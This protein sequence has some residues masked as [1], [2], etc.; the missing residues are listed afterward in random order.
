MLHRPSHIDDTGAMTTR[1]TA[2]LTGQVLSWLGDAFQVVA[3]PV[4]IVVA[5]GSA[6][7][8]AAAITATTVARLVFTLFGGVWADR[9]QPRIVMA[10]SDA[11]RAACG[12]VLACCFWAGAWSTPVI[13]GCAFVTAAAGAFY[14]SLIHI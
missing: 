12:L 8:M 6:G 10:A 1:M 5:G 14:L 7:Q 2:V 4:A 9:V 13:V 11:V 3:L